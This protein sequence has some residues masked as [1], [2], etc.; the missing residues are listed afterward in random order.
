MAID[1]CFMQCN[2]NWFELT[3][4]TKTWFLNSSTPIWV[5]IVHIGDLIDD[6]KAGCHY[7]DG[8]FY[9]DWLADAQEFYKNGWRETQHLD[10]SGQPS[11]VDHIDLFADG[12][13]LQSDGLLAG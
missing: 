2:G 10:D 4:M 11:G 5:D 6:Y 8:R 12:M 9:F 1:R 13:L 3:P 7:I